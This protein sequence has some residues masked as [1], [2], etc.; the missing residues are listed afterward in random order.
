MQAT[1]SLLPRSYTDSIHTSRRTYILLTPFSAISPRPPRRL[2]DRAGPE[3]A[4]HRI[5][6][7]F[8]RLLVALIGP[9]H[10]L[11]AS[12]S[13]LWYAVVVSNTLFV[14]GAL[15]VA[16]EFTL[17]VRVLSSRTVSKEGKKVRFFG[18]PSSVLITAALL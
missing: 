4:S 8:R 6:A 14:W 13:R 1:P 17:C 3:R 18:I 16:L 12:R 11:R 9:T 15:E 2:R 7:A 10:V 5:A